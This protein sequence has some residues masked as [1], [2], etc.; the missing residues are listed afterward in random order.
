[1]MVTERPCLHENSNCVEVLMRLGEISK[2]EKRPLHYNGMNIRGSRLN[3]CN[4]VAR[5]EAKTQMPPAGSD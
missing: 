2:M 5:Q 4:L 1:M 3:M